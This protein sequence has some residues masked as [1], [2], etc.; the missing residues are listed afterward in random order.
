[1]VLYMTFFSNLFIILEKSINS[2]SIWRTV[3]GL[4]HPLWP[5]RRRSKLSLTHQDYCK[6][7]GHKVLTNKTQKP[8]NQWVQQR[9]NTNRI[10]ALEWTVA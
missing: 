9:N 10:S 7:G 2:S 4:S 3:K 6:T 5:I 1:M 8:H